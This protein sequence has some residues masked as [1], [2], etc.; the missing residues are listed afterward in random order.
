MLSKTTISIE[1]PKTWVQGCIPDRWTRFGMY[2]TPSMLK[3]IVNAAH[4][5]LWC[6]LDTRMIATLV[7][8]EKYLTVEGGKLSDR[9]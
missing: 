5:I 4:A 6:S 3:S 1:N 8:D 2:R 7:A 9:F